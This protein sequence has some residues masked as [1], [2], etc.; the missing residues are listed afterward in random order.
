L[1]QIGGKDYKSWKKIIQTS[2]LEEKLISL[3]S[4]R[5]EEDQIDENIIVS[6][7]MTEEA[8]SH[9]EEEKHSGKKKK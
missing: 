6:L 4:L 8:A 9:A 1:S 5:K 2:S 3:I 7:K